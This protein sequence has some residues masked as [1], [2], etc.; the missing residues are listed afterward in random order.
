MTARLARYPRLI[1]LVAGALA[2]LGFAP[3]YI[4]PALL[5]SIALLFIIISAAPTPRAAFWQSWWWGVGFFG[6]GLYWITIA[7]TIDMAR[8]GW[9][10][11]F[12]L[13]GISG[14]LAFFPAIA[15][16]VYA[17]F[18]QPNITINAFLF[19]FVFFASEWARS[20]V[21]T[22]FP[23]NLMGYSWGAYDE[24][25]QAA[26]LV[27]VMGLSL[28]SWLVACGLAVLLSRRF[29]YPAACVAAVLA[30]LSYGDARLQQAHCH[31]AASEAMRAE[32]GADPA[33]SRCDSQDDKTITL[34]IVQANIPQSLKWDPERLRENLDL[35]RELTMS[36]G[37]KNADVVIWPES[38]FPFVVP[39]EATHIEPLRDLLK[40][41]QLLITG[42]MIREQNP[43]AYTNSMLVLNHKAKIVARYDKHHLVPFGEYVPLRE[44]L[45]I[46]KITQGSVD[47]KSGEYPRPI[48][49]GTSSLRANVESAAIE[50]SEKDW[51]A[52]SATP[53]RDD[54]VR[55]DSDL[56]LKQLARNIRPLICYEVIFAQYSQGRNANDW[57]L[58]LTND[59]WYGNSTGPYQHL[60]MARFRAIEQGVPMVR[61]AGTGISAVYDGYGRLQGSLPLGTQGVLDI[62]LPAPNPQR[63]LY[64][65]LSD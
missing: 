31:S 24:S 2:P 12:A 38:A 30:L 62:A 26:S 21:L 10:I 6:A 60:E 48:A 56:S 61:V 54:D 5:L 1:L 49:L 32:S 63:S 47:F 25:A 64:S 14:G 33:Q 17:A 3:F 13:A 46:E 11:P 8:F 28:F 45:P 55:V 27:S 7:L 58:N 22:G 40:P 34:R 15:G 23:W 65:Q 16:W 36:K 57:L 37:L 43:L 9:M 41:D 53:P 35:Y 44:W 4:W 52:A 51:I 39:A 20:H 59:G 18:K 50:K 29:I 19:S 42:A